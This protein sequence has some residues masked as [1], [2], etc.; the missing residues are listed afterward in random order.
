MVGEEGREG[1]KR[2]EGE[3]ERG[4]E[5]REAKGEREGTGRGIRQRDSEEKELKN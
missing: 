2:K 5:G 1:N 3:G 4:R